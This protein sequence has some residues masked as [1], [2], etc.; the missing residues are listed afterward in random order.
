[1]ARVAKMEGTPTEDGTVIRQAAD[2]YFSL[3]EELET[4][5]AATKVTTSGKTAWR[6]ACV[7]RSVDPVVLARAA[8][9]LRDIGD[10][11]EKVTREWHLLIGYLKAL[12][13]YDKLVPGLFDEFDIAM[14]EES[15]A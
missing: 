10:D 1:M 11:P 9:M 2:D 8:D 3:A 6:K 12:G 5:R 7:E 15:A 14:A 13:F 4:K